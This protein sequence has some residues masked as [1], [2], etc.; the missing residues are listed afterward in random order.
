[1]PPFRTCLGLALLLGRAGPAFSAAPAFDVMPA[2]AEAAAAGAALAVRDGFVAVARGPADDRVQSGLRGLIAA[3]RQR[4]GRHLSVET[5]ASAPQLVVVCRSPGPAWP[6]LG[7]DERY[8]LAISPRSAVLQAETA[9]GL[10]RGLATLQ[11]LL[12]RD[13]PGWSLPG[14]SIVDA[15]RFAWRG[16]LIDVCRHW[17][18]PDVIRRNLDGMALVK[19]NVLHLH[20]TD[21]Q[22]FR[23]EI[24]RHPELTAQGSDGH[25]YT[26]DEMRALVAYAAQRAIRV[27]PEFDLPG[28]ATAWF[29]S[30]PELA[31]G[32]GPFRIER[33]WGIFDP[34]MDPTN[35]AA[36]RLLADVFAEM[37]AVFPDRYVHIGGDENNGV[38]W[39]ANPRIQAFIQAHGLKG[40]A[41]LQTYFNRRVGVIFAGLGRRMI[42]WD[43]IL[44]P[45]L[46]TDAAI[47]SW[48]GPEALRQAARRGYDGILA[49]GYYIDLGHSAAEHYAADPAPP[50]AALNAAER[51]HVLGGE[52]TMWGEWVTPETI[53][54]RIWPRTGAI[55]ER[56]WSPAD[57]TNV[58]DMY[59]RL[60]ALSARLDEA[61]LRH[62]SYLEPMLIRLLGGCA[63]PAAVAALS[64]FIA[65][66]EPVSGDSPVRGDQEPG[67]DQWTPL[68]GVADAAR[69]DS[70]EGRHFAAE[71]TLALARPAAERAAG[72]APVRC[73]LT[74]WQASALAVGGPEGLAAQAPGLAPAAPLARQLADACAVGL[75]ALDVLAGGL[76]ATRDWTRAARGRLAAAAEAHDAVRLAL[77]PALDQLV[78]AAASVESR[79]D[80]PAAPPPEL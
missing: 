24:K 74:A 39:S 69:P 23:I 54:S 10:L 6:A 20:L 53:D 37:A 4:T 62:R 56:L 78:R 75:E 27:V 33:H 31:S 57:R 73:A 29:V 5:D 32:P 58:A 68:I 66:I 43:E 72:L 36:Y 52:A 45:D 41:G 79:P 13:G 15:P 59:R 26:Q 8:S 49:H 42:G 61:G 25:Y 76:P 19:L 7:D 16:L 38:Q 1:M 64:S 18:P 14:G 80:V 50:G 12:Q 40:N 3:W 60:E 47:E 17:E 67:A 70:P 77:L 9:A 21:D 71:V 63:R 30:H 51:A 35:E 46:P 48:R 44:Q 28:H 65:A 22:G 55:A 2:P 11:Q 34:V